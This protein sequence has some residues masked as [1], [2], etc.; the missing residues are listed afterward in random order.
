MG[1]L[2]KQVSL[3]CCLMIPDNMG[4]SW[5]GEFQGKCGLAPNGYARMVMGVPYSFNFLKSPVGALPYV[6]MTVME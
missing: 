1:L 5:K 6:T 2:P 4:F 3:E